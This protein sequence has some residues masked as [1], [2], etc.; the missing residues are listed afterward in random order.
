MGDKAFTVINRSE[1]R[2]RQDVNSDLSA[3]LH[4]AQH[5][6]VKKDLIIKPYHKLVKSL[7]DQTVSNLANA[8]NEGRYQGKPGWFVEN[9]CMLEAARS[10]GNENAKKI[11]ELNEQQ[12][13][14]AILGLVH[15]MLR[16]KSI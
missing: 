9:L 4:H 13:A 5:F 7:A 16:P 1:V 3:M 2:L 14:S 8:V 15:K 6:E 12:N 10:W 11:N